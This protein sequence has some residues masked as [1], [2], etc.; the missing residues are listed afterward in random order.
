MYKRL[1]AVIGLSVACFSAVAGERATDSLQTSGS[2]NLIEATEPWLTGNNAAGL[3]RWQWGGRSEALCYA[4]RKSGTL[5]NYAE[6]ATSTHWGA[7][8]KAYRRLHTRVAFYGRAGYENVLGRSMGG[9]VWIRPYEAPFDLVETD[10]QTAGEKQLE[11]YRL[12]GGVSVA[13]NKRLSMGARL[14]YAASNYAKRRDIRHVNTLMDLSLSVGTIYRLSKAWEM[15]ASYAH[16]RNV[17]QLRFSL[18]GAN[19]YPFSVLV[20]YGSFFGKMETT[21]G[22]DGYVKTQSTSSTPLYDGYHRF[23]LQLHGD[24]GAWMV[25]HEATFGWRRGYYGLELPTTVSYSKHNGTEWSYRMRLDWRRNATLHSWSAWA[26]GHSLDNYEQVYRHVVEEKEIRRIV[27]Y[28]PLHVGERSR[29]QLGLHYRGMRNRYAAFPNWLWEAGLQSAIHRRK[30]SV[31]PFYR[32]QNLYE[33][34]AFFN[35]RHNRVWGIHQGGLAMGMSYRQ[36]GGGLKTDGVYATPSSNQQTPPTL[37]EVLAHEYAYITAQ[38]MQVRLEAT[39]GR[40][41]GSVQ[42]YFSLRYVGE[43]AFSSSL[44]RSM[45]HSCDAAVGCRF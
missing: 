23:G 2:L 18:S 33:G 37:N 1:Y 26:S 19:E 40:Q 9:S 27:Y 36:G 30:A 8:V 11:T 5:A 22:S 45:R 15:G 16:R 4:G 39:Y 13:L 12:A 21:G 43:R 7:D 28:D 32:K 42:G 6:A 29:W 17:E 3:Y 38:R 44:A 14:D 25:H 20:S 41:L 34:E 35:L 24:G 31:Y 10:R